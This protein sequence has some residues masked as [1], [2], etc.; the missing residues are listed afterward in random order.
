MFRRGAASGSIAVVRGGAAAVAPADFR[1]AY[2]AAGAHEC[3]IAGRPPFVLEPGHA[4]VVERWAN[5]EMAPLAIAPLAAG[6]V[7]LVVSVECR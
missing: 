3:V 5:V 2:A 4:A 1:L 6:A 7:A